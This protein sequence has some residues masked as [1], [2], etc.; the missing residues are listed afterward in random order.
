MKRTLLFFALIAIVSTLMASE[1]IAQKLTAEEIV[2]KHLESIGKADDRTKMFNITA[3]GLVN[4]SQLSTA[5]APSGGKVVF[6]SEGNKALFA[7]TFQS[8]S[9]QSETIKFDG[10]NDFIGFSVPGARSVFG[11]YLYKYKTALKHNLLGGVLQKGWAFTDLPAHNAKISTGGTKKIDGREAYV[12]NYEPKKGSDVQVK[13]YF[14]KENFRH[15]RTEYLRTNQPGMGHNPNTSSSLVETHEN[16]TED[17]SDFKTEY[18]VTLPR[19]YKIT[20]YSERMTQTYEGKYVMSFTDFY[21]NS[22]LEAATFDFA[23]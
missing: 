3:V 16:L 20:L 12:I 22:K 5:A 13:V 7:M 15:I 17:F 14:D 8:S 19:G 4:Y 11:E 23:K 18:G 9:Y 6:A 10:N 2:A 1:V 21:Y